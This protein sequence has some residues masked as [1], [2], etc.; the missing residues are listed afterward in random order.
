MKKPSAFK[1]FD[2]LTFG[3]PT[4]CV[5]ALA[6]HVARSDVST[7][8][9]ALMWACAF[10]FLSIYALLVF[11]RYRSLNK[12]IW[13][14]KHGFMVNVDEWAGDRSGMDLLIERTANSWKEAENYPSL[15]IIHKN[16]IWVHFKPGPI[17]RVRNQI[18]KPVAGYVIARGFDMVVGYLERGQSL[19]RTAFE[20]E[21]GHLI[22]GHATDS[23]DEA[24]HHA[25]A[26]RHG[27]P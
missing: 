27:I 14:P 26:K 7:E 12:F 21:L 9:K 18:I 13:Y 20:H 22:Q 2:L 10:S 6:F 16:V 5:F 23:W 25:R 24:E 3:I 11:W 19:D 15:K 17:T 8:S 4:A 1:F